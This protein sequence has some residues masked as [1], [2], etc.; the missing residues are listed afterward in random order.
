M[1]SNNT[2]GYGLMGMTWRDDQVDDETAFTAMREAIKMGAVHWSTAEFYGPKENPNAGIH[3]LRRYF[4]RYPE[5][6]KK[7]SIYVKGCFNIKTFSTDSS[8][9]GVRKSLHNCQTILGSSK[10]VDYFGP[11]RRDKN[12]SI[13]ETM[14]AFKA[15]IKEGQIK[16]VFLSEVGEE[17]IRKAHAVQPLSAVEVEFSMFTQDILENGVGKATKDLDISILAYSPLGRGFLAGAVKS[18]NDIPKGD[19]RLVFDRFQGENLEKNVALAEKIR[20]FAQR[21]GATPAQVAIAWMFSN[22]DKTG[23]MIPIPGATKIERVHENSSLIS[24]ST[25]QIK[26]LNELVPAAHVSGGRANKAAEALLW[27]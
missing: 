15:L 12:V 7:V 2:I 26:E 14:E 18:I 17:T 9:D 16:G 21:I 1:T 4:D 8:A 3:L 19:R 10:A 25:E 23:K 13:E 27:G 6:A 5:D 11:A 24:L 22:P 20:N